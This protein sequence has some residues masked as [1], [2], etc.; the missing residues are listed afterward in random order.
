MLA[1]LANAQSDT[2][3][4]EV[5]VR[6]TKRLSEA[7]VR[8]Y[9]KTKPGLTYTKAQLDEDRLAIEQSLGIVSKVSITPVL[10]GDGGWQI[11][12][13]IEEF[14]DIK[15]ISI[16][17]AGAL[18][19][20]EILKLPIF[21]DRLQLGKPFNRQDVRPVG[22][23]IN[24]LYIKRGLGGAVEAVGMVPSSPGTVVIS[25]RERKFG[26]IEVYGET[27]T[28][29][30]VFQNL[31]LARPGDPFNSELLLQDWRRL[32]NTQWFES[33][34]F[35]EI[36]PTQDESTADIRFK[37]K[38]QRTGIFNI[39]VTLDPQN[40]LAGT[41]SINEQN[42][43]GT[44]QAVGI[45]FIQGTLG[46]G[47]SASL[48]YTNPFIDSKNTTLRASVYDRV[49]FRFQ[50]TLAGGGI[51]IGNGNQYFERRT[52][53]NFGLS[54]PF[55]QG[56][57][58]DLYSLGFNVRA[59]RINTTSNITDPNDPNLGNGLAL[60][61]QNGEVG[62]FGFTGILNNRDV[63]L[64]P[65]RGAFV[66]LDVET[67]YSII[68]ADTTSFPDGPT[69]RNNFSRVSFDY[70]NYFSKD[71]RR[72]KKED[73]NPIV[74][75]FRLRGGTVLGDVPFFEQFFAG[76]NDSI[77]GYNEDRFWGTNLLFGSLE[78]RL[79]TDRYT[80]NALTTVLFIDYGA[81]WGGYPAVG[82]FSQRDVFRPSLGYGFGVRV[83]TPLGPIRLDFGY[84][85]DGGNR[86]H[87]GIG[88]SF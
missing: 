12:V 25:I 76:G 86:L 66:R 45:N 56:G 31:I 71:R 50:N 26:N 54:R 14:A 39:G 88:P 67:G 51:G 29:P 2:V 17:G 5:V 80:D 63:D 74:W 58:R 81:A 11:V 9:M 77:R 28:R 20:E 49:L 84:A 52:G 35:P 55:R 34:E 42:L 87:F 57:F 82:N 6:G 38:Q 72:L 27:N 79:P 46:A 41:I 53:F 13:D 8:T 78:Y 19:V 73:P 65:S 47:A 59:E 61:Q 21:Q 43:N 85:G 62:V 40:Q 68:N 75:A 37:V 4:K 16:E 7:V 30:R 15:E 64:D 18:K 48:D 60:I 10:L 83:R 70:R 23:A 69:G 32:Q 44:G 22:L 3:V 24:D 36:I 1:G 33:V